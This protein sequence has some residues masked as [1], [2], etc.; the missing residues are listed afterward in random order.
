MERLHADVDLAGFFQRLARASE[1]VLFLDFDGTLAPFRDN[2]HDVVPYDGIPERLDAVLAE[3]HTRVVV[4][5]GRVVWEMPELLQLHCTPEI[6]GTHG[7]QR[8]HP[9]GCVEGPSL[10]AATERALSE[11][12]AR[13]QSLQLGD[14][15]ERKPATVAVHTRGL[16]EDEVE[17]LTGRVEA[18]WSPLARDSSAELHAF[19]GGLE[20]RVPG[21]DKGTAVRTVLREM[22]APIA[23]Y[24]GDDHTD[25]DAFRAL[26]GYGLRVLVR[27]T[28]R[29]TGAD[30]WIRP[31]TELLAWLD[32]WRRVAKGGT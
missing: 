31:P 2:R 14:R 30:V 20:M 13:A 29:E 7:W 8:R 25:E 26:D 6:W 12:H 17:S 19:D 5:T 9:D 24:L 21:C 16:A 28:F 11:A 32:R 23:A 3:G 15:L 18:L 10:D 4:V 27:S 22:E 1:R